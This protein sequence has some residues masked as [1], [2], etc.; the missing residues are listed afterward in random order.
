MKT[1]TFV[2]NNGDI[3]NEAFIDE[4]NALMAIN[5]AT[6]ETVQLFYDFDEIHGSWIDNETF[7]E[8]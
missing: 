4:R 1:F 7:K 2:S 6:G 3:Y 8:F 5:D